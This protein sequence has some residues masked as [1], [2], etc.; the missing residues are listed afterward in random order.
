M[1]SRH[2]QL[3]VAAARARLP[4]LI[5]SVILAALTLAAGAGLL[6][7]SGW[8][9]TASAMAGLGLLIGLEIFAPAAGIRALAVTRTVARYL[10]RLIGH[11]STL[12]LLAEL[13]V[14]LFQRLL[15]VESAA[16]ERMRRGDLLNR[17][18]AD[19]DRLDHLFLRVA[20]PGLA[21]FMLVAVVGIG[22]ILLVDGLIGWLFMGG[23]LVGGSMALWLGDRA[24]RPVGAQLGQITPR[25]R[26]TVTE[27][28][29]GLADLRSLGAWDRMVSEVLTDARRMAWLQAR[30]GLLEGLGR[31]AILVIGLGLAWLVLWLG[32]HQHEEQSIG[33]PLVVLATLV[34]IGIIEAWQP[35]PA[36]WQFL[37]TCRRSAD[38]INRLDTL[39]RERRDG[40]PPP[41]SYRLEIRA[42]TFRYLPHTDPVLDGLSLEISPGQPLLITGPSGCGKSTLGRLLAG[43][44]APDGGEILL[45][46]IDLQAMAADQRRRLIA[47]LPQQP[48]IFHDSLRAN[49]AL[50]RPGAD[51]DSLM[52]V[53]GQTGL[54]SLVSS[55]DAGLDT[56]LGESG[57][58]LSGGEARRLALARLLLAD[59]PVLILDEPT[60]GVDTATARRITAGLA[61]HFADRSVV[62]IA[63]EPAHF[64][65]D[66][67][68]L[69][70]AA[71]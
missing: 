32:L 44:L 16:L 71:A 40:L 63:H 2:W 67:R 8:F 10:E 47:H 25:L 50:A 43:Q 17:L 13:R 51:D 12:R 66:C 9:I 3:L 57:F 52:Q 59:F 11:E 14:G 21:A 20:A 39:P 64:D 60:A 42:L 36:A 46:G 56:W 1:K 33:A 55:L 19:V 30:L 28:F 38:R 37:E 26:T 54:E 6:A 15:G 18:T 70:M 61:D 65:L 22:L 41:D 49:L 24:A 68:H 53:L 58:R 27:L 5:A 62:I 23:W 48:V 31:S 34:V 69:P 7:L 4:W 45:G 35:L 29:S